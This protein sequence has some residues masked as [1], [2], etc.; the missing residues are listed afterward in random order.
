MTDLT[1][2]QMIHLNKLIVKVFTYPEIHE[3]FKEML[4]T[5]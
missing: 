5:E 1:D 2:K 3:S 4:K